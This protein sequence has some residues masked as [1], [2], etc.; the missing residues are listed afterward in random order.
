MGFPFT[1]A[2][3]ADGWASATFVRGRQAVM[4]RSRS[5]QRTVFFIIRQI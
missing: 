2:S 4:A 5:K 3:G 1:G